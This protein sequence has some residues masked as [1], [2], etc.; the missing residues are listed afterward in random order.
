MK[1]TRRK[2]KQQA[3]A[4]T[5]RPSESAVQQR[6]GAASPLAGPTRNEKSSGD[7]RH[8]SDGHRLPRSIL[9]EFWS[10]SGQIVVEGCV[11]T[12]QAS[13][14]PGR[15]WQEWHARVGPCGARPAALGIWLAAA[16][17]RRRRCAGAEPGRGWPGGRGLGALAPLRNAPPP[18]LTGRARPSVRDRLGLVAAGPG[19]A[20]W[21]SESAAFA[22][23]VASAATWRRKLGWQCVQQPD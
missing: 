23:A 15:D 19:K 18:S 4:V 13:V 8:N 9:V 16:G 10:N 12:A 1:C 2:R 11:P 5:L 3:L 21:H 20:R 17:G 7:A 14:K 22:A 6:N